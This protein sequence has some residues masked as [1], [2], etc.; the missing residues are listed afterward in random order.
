MFNIFKRKKN[1]QRN[2][3]EQ[4][5][6]EQA[7]S[8]IINNY[9]NTESP[10][11]SIDFLNFQNQLE[12]IDSASVFS[13]CHNTDQYPVIIFI[14][15][16][17]EKVKDFIH[18]LNELSKL[19]VLQYDYESVDSDEMLWTVSSSEMYSDK[20]QNFFIFIKSILKETNEK[21]IIMIHHS[22]EFRLGQLLIKDLTIK[23]S[24]VSISYEKILFSQDYS[25]INNETCYSSTLMIDNRE[26]QLYY[27]ITGHSKMIPFLVREL[28][29]A[30]IKPLGNFLKKEIH[31]QRAGV[32][33]ISQTS[34]YS[35]FTLMGQIHTTGADIP[36]RLIFPRKLINLFPD[37]VCTTIKGK[38]LQINKEL[39]RR[40]FPQFYRS[41]GSFLIRD[42]LSVIE[43]RDLSLICQNYFS[44]NSISG[45]DMRKLFF[46]RV[47][48]EEKTRVLRIPFI[49]AS[50]FVNHLPLRLKEDFQRSSA[51]SQSYNDLL[52]A[53]EKMLDHIYSELT[54]GKL[55][56]SYKAK[57][58]LEKEPGSR[59]KE[60]KTLRLK[61]LVGDKRFINLIS[62]MDSKKA[63]V[64]LSNMKNGL[65]VDT[66]IYQTDE[67]IKL[68]PY[69]SRNR[70]NELRE[71]I[72]YTQ[73]KVKS[74]QI[75]IN[76]ICD[77]IEDFNSFIRD[78][79]EKEQKR[80]NRKNS[81]PHTLSNDM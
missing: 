81:L 28:I 53:N 25:E 68:K 46:Y 75:D 2:E 12:N 26:I 1:Q 40:D 71:D 74:S 52:N 65:I 23:Q 59:V 16:K 18:D 44:S 10:L 69:L 42:F 38:I 31:I 34:D 63:Q 73:G 47:K 72:K 49:S 20:N 30:Q 54:E 36:Y 29:K 3:P 70:F 22:Q 77:S 62:R 80:E 41:H 55:L 13:L 58:I 7:I 64:L 33:N 19:E 79:L 11:E 39:F 60:S 32:G 51:Y 48:G 5:P 14:R 6:L 61:K 9:F 35:D 50:V 57:Y 21:D 4:P 56:L 27:L 66:F 24:P 76:R 67:L 43:E 15:K 37:Y 78:Y 8:Q 17:I 45:E